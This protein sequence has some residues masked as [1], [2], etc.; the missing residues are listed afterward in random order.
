MP[1]DITDYQFTHCGFGLVLVPTFDFRVANVAWQVPF[2]LNWMICGFM[3][4]KRHGVSYLVLYDLTCALW[5]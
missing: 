3:A 4:D 2:V 5:L 1:M